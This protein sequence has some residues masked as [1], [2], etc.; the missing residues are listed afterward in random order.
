MSKHLFFF[1]FKNHLQKIPQSNSKVKAICSAIYTQQP[2]GRQGG[3]SQEAGVKASIFVSNKWKSKSFLCNPDLY[4]KKIC[5]FN[6][7]HSGHVGLVGL[8]QKKSTAAWKLMF[9]SLLLFDPR[10]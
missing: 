10:S 5:V 3:N 4:T 7:N 1:F 2:G 6:R 8:D 9:G